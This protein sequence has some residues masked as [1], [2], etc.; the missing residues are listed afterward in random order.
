[1]FEDLKRC[2]IIAEIGGN[3]TTYDEAKA[4]IDAAKLTGV[5]CVKLQ[6]FRAETV[7]CKNAYFDMETT[8]RISQYDY[9]KKYEI[10]KELHRKIFDYADS[11][12]L[13]WFSTPSH[14]DDVDMLLSLGVKAF[15]IGSDDATNTPLIRYIAATGLPVIISTGMCTMD[16]IHESVDAIMCEGNRK[17]VI[18]H[19]VS[20][21][22]TRPKDVNLKALPALQEEF[23]EFPVGFSDH[24][25]ST[26]AS[27]SA[28]ALGAKVVERHFTLDND[29][30]GPDHIISS[31]PTQMKYIV[32]G[33]RLVE[34][35]TGPGTKVPSAEEKRNAL[36]NRKSIVTLRPIKKGEVFSSDNLTV[37]RP[38]TGIE[39]KYYKAIIGH[40][41]AADIEGDNVMTWEG[42]QG[43]ELNLEGRSCPAK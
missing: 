35:M 26:L 13:D 17:I 1:M 24:T 12:A 19:T 20:G 25:I 16:E 34:K 22:P 3:F 11:K 30:E 2:Y 7:T 32:D 23:P 33:I 8:G 43:G 5:D 41:A 10:S 28:V 31:T 14:Q 29:A 27:I 9:F 15:K 42:V 4:L 40:T 39:P 37:K 36:N 6:T 38:G 18:M 21:Y